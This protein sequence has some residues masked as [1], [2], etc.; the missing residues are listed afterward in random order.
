MTTA[1][2]DKVVSLEQSREMED[3]VNGLPAQPSTP[4]QSLSQ[5]QAKYERE[6]DSDSDYTDH[7]TLGLHYDDEANKGGVLPN[8]TFSIGGISAITTPTTVPFQSI[9]IPKPISV[10]EIQTCP[11]TFIG[12][13][14][15]LVRGILY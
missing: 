10:F 2:G 15:D 1:K 14:H 13:H 12:I 9:K 4:T 7:D 5:S 3:T 8:A 11:R 6:I